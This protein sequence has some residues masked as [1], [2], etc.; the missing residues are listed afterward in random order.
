MKFLVQFVT[1]YPASPT[2][3]LVLFVFVALVCSDLRRKARLRRRRRLVYYVIDQIVATELWEARDVEH[4]PLAIKPWDA[5]LHY[6]VRDVAIY[7]PVFHTDLSRY[8]P[9][10]IGVD[11]AAWQDHYKANEA[12]RQQ[13]AQAKQLEALARHKREAADA[14]LESIDR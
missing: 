12:Q 13:A 3:V 11:C 10:E 8:T 6:L 7:A 9:V 5:V 4:T 14:Y 1:D 2:V